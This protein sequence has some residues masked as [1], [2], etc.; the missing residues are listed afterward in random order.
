MKISFIKT[1]GSGG[2]SNTST[3]ARLVSSEFRVIEWDTSGLVTTYQSWKNLKR[4]FENV[5]RRWV[6]LL[7]VIPSTCSNES[8]RIISSMFFLNALASN[9]QV[10]VKQWLVELYHC[11]G[12]NWIFF[13]LIWFLLWTPYMYLRSIWPILLSSYFILPV[14]TTNKIKRNKEKPLN[15]LIY[16]RL[17]PFMILRPKHLSTRP[18]MLM[19]PSSL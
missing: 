9:E 14:F 7:E 19:P 4:P 6:L 17:S 10:P 8:V 3:C 18:Y 1:K 12:V 15:R 5:E 11:S 13:L 16:S 2:N